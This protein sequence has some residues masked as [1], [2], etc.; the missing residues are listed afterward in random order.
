MSTTSI[1]AVIRFCV[2]NHHESPPA[3]YK[4]NSFAESPIPHSIREVPVKGRGPLPAL[5]EAQHIPHTVLQAQPALSGLSLPTFLTQHAWGSPSNLTN[6]EISF[7]SHSLGHLLLP[8][9]ARHRGTCVNNSPFQKARLA[10]VLLTL[11]FSGSRK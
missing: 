5:W 1:N 10:L 8:S 7:S 4:R 2:Q 11:H 6:R 3:S 9:S